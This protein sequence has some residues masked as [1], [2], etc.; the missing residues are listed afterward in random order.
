M[1]DQLADSVRTPAIMLSLQLWRGD[2]R[3]TRQQA[4]RLLAGRGLKTRG[5]SDVSRVIFQTNSQNS[6]KETSD[7]EQV[8]EIFDYI[9]A[10]F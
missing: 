6:I 2:R 3:R 10:T 4:S 9:N 1:C 8:R 5:K 7:P